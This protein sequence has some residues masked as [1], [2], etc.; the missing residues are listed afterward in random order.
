MP[1]RPIVLIHGYSASGSSF[2][3]WREIFLERGYPANDIHV[4][5]YKSL[6]NEVTLRDLAEG[7]DR[8]LRIQ[9]G[10][11]ADEEFDAVVHSTGML[12]I[13]AW[14]AS[15]ASR[16]SRLKHLIALAPVT[17]GSPL[18]HK[19]RSWLGSVFR[20]NKE[21]G[22]DFLEAGDLILDGLELGSKFTWDLAQLDLIGEKPFYGTSGDTPFAFVFCGASK[23]AFP[24]SLISEDGSD[25]TVRLA[26]AALN[27][28]KIDLDL[29]IDRTRDPDDRRVETAPWSNIDIP[30]IPIEKL[31]H[32]SIMSQPSEKL[33]ELVMG[34]L[35]VD[36][37]TSFAAWHERATAHASRV[38]AK[39][40]K[41]KGSRKVARWQQFVVHVIDERGD[42][43]PDYFIEFIKKE[44]GKRKWAPIKDHEMHVRP[45]STDRS[46]RCFHVNLDTLG[47]DEKRG[48]VP[49]IRL[50]ASSGTVL[51]KYDGYSDKDVSMYADVESDEASEEWSEVIDLASLEKITLFHP[52]TTTLVEIKLNREPQPPIGRNEVFYFPDTP[53]ARQAAI[54]EQIRSA[55][56]SEKQRTRWKSCMT[57]LHAIVENTGTLTTRATCCRS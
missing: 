24:L 39:L 32:G 18:A 12:V 45:Y 47:V 3:R 52:F 56:L 53:E 23:Y 27:T 8:A 17:F 2:D 15:Y 28:R 19:G 29:T 11:D 48:D 50:T 37:A 25:G 5:T 10:L 46:Y 33:I 49:G 16:R 55:E 26:G 54:A 9:T 4:C 35:A 42:P 31:D 40:R 41:L 34:A 38:F 22:P 1:N 57:N 6:T 21:A 13:R 14:M 44:K 7:M 36:D 30:V 20:G 43:I 51:V